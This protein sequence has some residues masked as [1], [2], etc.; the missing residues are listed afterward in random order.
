[1]VGFIVHVGLVEGCIGGCADGCPDGCILG[2]P[3]GA[4]VGFPDGVMF[5]RDGFEDEGIVDDGCDVGR[6]TFDGILEE[7]RLL[8]MFE[9]GLAVFKVGA[10]DGCDVGC[11]DGCREG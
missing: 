1:M 9:D 7:G 2:W 10:V 4:L 6:N 11:R 8:G 3:L 5:E